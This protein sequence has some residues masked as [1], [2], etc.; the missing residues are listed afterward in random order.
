MIFLF[1]GFVIAQSTNDYKARNHKLNKNR[2]A[3]SE[4][5]QTVA[6]NMNSDVQ[7]DY[8]KRNT[9][10]HKQKEEVSLIHKKEKIAYD[11]RELNRKFSKSHYHRFINK[12]QP[13]D[14]L[15]ENE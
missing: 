13:D 3:L 1:T 6:V 2:T 10:F 11:Y 8:R 14:M 5:T 9:K 12:I 7:I 4:V 15:S